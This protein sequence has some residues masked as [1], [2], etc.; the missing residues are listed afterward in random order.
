MQ[1]EIKG[2]NHPSHYQ[3]NGKEAIDYIEMFRLSFSAGN[4]IKYLWRAGEKE[5]ESMEKD[6]AKALWYF[7]REAK[8]ILKTCPFSNQLQANKAVFDQVSQIFSLAGIP[9]AIQFLKEN[10]VF[11]EPVT[12]ED[13]QK[14]SVRT[15][16]CENEN[17]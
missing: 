5:G 14:T 10:V 9:E 4:I 15:L 2:V 17:N 13:D 7:E 8:F 6:K 11:P 1:T 3:R 12:F 16:I